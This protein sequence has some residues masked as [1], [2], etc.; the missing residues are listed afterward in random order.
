MSNVK[1]IR[2]WLVVEAANIPVSVDA[3]TYLVGRVCW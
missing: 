3:E 2:A 1:Q